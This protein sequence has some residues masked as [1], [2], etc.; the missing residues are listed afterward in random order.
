MTFVGRERIFKQED[1]RP[2]FR[3]VLKALCE[4]WISIYRLAFK[5]STPSELNDNN[6]EF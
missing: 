1:E 4:E 2:E 3:D 6:P 5:Y